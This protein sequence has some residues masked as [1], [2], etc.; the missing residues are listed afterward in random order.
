MRRIILICASVS[1]A[2]SAGVAV[3]SRSSDLRRAS[4]R[5]RASPTFCFDEYWVPS[6]SGRVSDDVVVKGV[7][8]CTYGHAREG[9]IV[10]EQ[11]AISA[12]AP[13]T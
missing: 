11:D 6:G 3:S 4:S 13:L 10:H 5:T 2:P 1:A 12:Q 8:D 7:E 9:V